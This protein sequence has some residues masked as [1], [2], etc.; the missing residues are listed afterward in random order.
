MKKL[1]RLQIKTGKIMKTEELSF[2][3]GGYDIDSCDCVCYGYGYMVALDLFEC[4]ALCTAIGAIGG[5]QA[6]GPPINF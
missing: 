6:G 3:R 1:G 2:I 4:K 5:C